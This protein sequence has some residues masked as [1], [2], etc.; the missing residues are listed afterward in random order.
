MKSYN[1]H[2]KVLI[3]GAICL[4]LLAGVFSYKLA[5]YNQVAQEEKSV[6]GFF[7]I[8]GDKEDSDAKKI[9]DAI[10]RVANKDFTEEE[11][12]DPFIITSKDSA[13][14]RFIKQFYSDYVNQEAG[15]SDLSADDVANNA[16]SQLSSGDMPRAKYGLK[17]I[18]IFGNTTSTNIRSYG[19]TFA[20]IY[21]RNMSKVANNEAKYSSNLLEIAKVYEDISKELLKIQVPVEISTPH[22]AIVNNYQILADSFRLINGQA[23]D[24]VKALLGVRSAKITMEENDTMFIN[25]SKYFKNNGIIFNKSEAGYIWN[26]NQ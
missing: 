10:D 11:I 13:T 21:F 4:S 18:S 20:E 8:T 14:D 2:H 15:V 22:V 5:K 9:Q 3:I 17:D 6:L 24:P 16:I 7:D 1:P 19:N 25:I 12:D 26:I 23:S